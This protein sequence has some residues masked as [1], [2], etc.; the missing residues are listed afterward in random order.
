MSTLDFG[1]SL[2]EISILGTHNSV[3]RSNCF[4]LG[5]FQQCQANSLTVQLESG[6]RALDIRVKHDTD[7]F[8]A[9]DR[10]CDLGVNFDTILTEVRSFLLSYPS[11]TVL[12]HVV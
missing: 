2:R 5:S 6:I 10:S 12:M 3:G 9:Y 7:R 11:E 4:W 1:L 8:Q